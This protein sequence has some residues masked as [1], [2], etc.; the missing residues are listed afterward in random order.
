MIKNE[1][2]SSRQVSVILATSL[3][4]LEFSPQIFEKY[5]NIKLKEVIPL[6]YKESNLFIVNLKYVYSQHNKH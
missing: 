4:T 5:S 2:C 3:V 6:C 1:Y